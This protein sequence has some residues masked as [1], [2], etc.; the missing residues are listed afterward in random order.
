MTMEKKVKSDDKMTVKVWGA[1]GSLPAPG[2]KTVKYGGNTS[3]LEV[4]AGGNLVI[5]DAGSGIRD[6]SYPLLKEGPV[7]ASIF[8]SHLHWDH[9]MGLPFFVPAYMKQNTFR[10]YGEKKKFGTLK[11]HL[12]TQMS[13]PFFPV[14]LDAFMASMSYTD[15]VAGDSF[16][17]GEI[18]VSAHQAN[19]PDGCLAYRIEYKGSRVRT[20]G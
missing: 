8:F 2:P 9:I 17:I 15:I 4:R 12:S 11:D 5:F 18:K 6:L 19:H 14:H 7:N 1:R 16:T 3:C 10:L 20:Q 13:H